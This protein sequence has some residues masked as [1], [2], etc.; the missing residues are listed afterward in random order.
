MVVDA[1][2]LYERID[3]YIRDNQSQG[4][5]LEEIIDNIDSGMIGE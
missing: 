5:S 3:E 2:E 1:K 4:L